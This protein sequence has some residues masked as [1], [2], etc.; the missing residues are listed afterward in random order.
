M[1]SSAW[2][3][4]MESLLGG[5]SRHTYAAIF[6][7][8][9]YFCI[10]DE[11]PLHLIPKRT[12]AHQRHTATALIVNPECV[13]SLGSEIPHV[14][15]LRADLL[16]GFALQGAIAWVRNR[17]LDSVLPFWLSQQM[18][19]FVQRARMDPATIN[20][21]P[22]E[23]RSVLLAADILVSDHRDP[24]KNESQESEAAVLFARNSY[25]P[26]PALIH[27]FHVAALRRYY[28][29]L[30]R[31][32]ALRLGDDQ[33][34]RR[35]FAHNEPVA[36]FFHLQLASKL[37]RVFGRAVKPSYV[38]MAS[39]LEGAEL[40]KHVDREQ[41]EFSVTLCV[42]FSPESVVSSSWPIVLDTPSGTATVYQALGDGLAYRGTQ[43]PHY[44]AP[45]GKGRTSTSIF[46]HYVDADFEG[47]LD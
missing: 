33:S 29:H 17:K 41:C 6:A 20:T 36:R 2:T 47:R 5:G 46:F 22:G 3:D 11:L 16:S 7:P 43:L 25:A 18:H 23:I 39:Y 13:F 30:I 37:N 19:D 8:D 34:S 42:D 21:L 24:L 32:G 40:K 9:R 26:L 14:L 12:A 35:Y 28:R 15:N 38:Y 27:P 4:W 1:S 10:L 45:L 44:R 31:S